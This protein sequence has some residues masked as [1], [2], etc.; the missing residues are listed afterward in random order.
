MPRGLRDLSSPTRGWTQAMAVKA[1]S[2]NHWNAKGFPSLFLFYTHF[3]DYGER[4]DTYIISL[5]VT[6][7]SEAAGGKGSDFCPLLASPKEW[8]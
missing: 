3:C 8:L 2:P 1:P 4:K 6:R 7:R 5:S